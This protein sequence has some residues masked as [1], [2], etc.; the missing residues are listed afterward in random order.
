MCNLGMYSICV[1][2]SMLPLPFT[3]KVKIATAMA[4]GEIP[5]RTA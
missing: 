3:P 5:V 2:P 4:C 1:S